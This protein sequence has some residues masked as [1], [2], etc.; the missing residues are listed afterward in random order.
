MKM[1]INLLKRAAALVA[2]PTAAILYGKV[3]V[4]TFDRGLF[5]A[6]GAFV[7]GSVLGIALLAGIAATTMA[8]R[9]RQ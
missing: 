3:C 1:K 2:G 8:F 4:D 6:P 5:N 7:A 9:K